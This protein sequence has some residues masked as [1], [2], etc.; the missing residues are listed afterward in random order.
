MLEV[1][2]RR[3]VCDGKERYGMMTKEESSGVKRGF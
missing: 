3:V 2:R 1:S